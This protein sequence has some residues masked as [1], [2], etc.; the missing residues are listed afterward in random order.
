MSDKISVNHGTKQGGLN[1]PFIFNIFYEDLITELQTC[2]Y[3]VTIKDLCVNIIYVVQMT[4]CCV[5][6]VLVVCKR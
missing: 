4:F 3:G 5:A 1:S 2:N 6:Q